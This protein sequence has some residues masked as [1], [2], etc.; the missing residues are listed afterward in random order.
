MMP[1]HIYIRAS[2]QI[3]VQ[4]PLCDKWMTDPVPCDAPYRRAIE[5]DYKPFLDPVASRRMGKILKRAIATSFT[6]ARQS[7]IACP[8]AV[9]TG[10]GLGC[11]DNTEKFLTALVTEGEAYLQP[12]NFINSTHNTI[13]SQIAVQMGCHGYNST[14]VHLGVS[15]ESAL[16]DAVMQFQTGSIHS[17]LVGGHDEMTPNYYTLLQR[18][19]FW[20]GSM[21][22][23]T[24]VSMMLSDSAP[25]DG[26]PCPVL[27]DMELLSGAAVA[28]IPQRAA[29][30]CERAGLVMDQVPC[31]TPDKVEALFGRSYTS[32]AFGVY[33][34]AAYLKQ[35]G[36]GAYLVYNNYHGE[37]ASVIL[38]KA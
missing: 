5:A 14:Y 29:R 25:D 12:T 13:S 3:S 26:T 22:G 16:L 31:I 27:Y 36:A 33:M 7:G 4:E 24:A 17:A 18:V 20:E 28:E 8:D 11:I 19:G 2:A 9:I 10:T 32:G 23:E 6:V 34:A 1:H 30:M 35:R 38:L 21:A 37:E 15:F